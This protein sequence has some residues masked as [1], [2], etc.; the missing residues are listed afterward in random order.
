MA[1]FH[2]KLN[3]LPKAYFDGDCHSVPSRLTAE[4]IDR[5]EDPNTGWWSS[6]QPTPEA[7]G[8]LRQLC[9]TD[10]SW[11]DTEEYVTSEWGS[12]L[13]IW[14]EDGRVFSVTFRFAPRADNRSLLDQF[15]AIAREGHYLLWDSD[16]KAVFEP[17][18]AVVIEHLR[19]SRAVLFLKDP[20]RAI[21]EA[22]K[23]SSKQ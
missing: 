4:D 15:L 2:F 17:D 10:N 16:T 1:A 23:Q 14:W 22:A 6:H 19:V 5:G 11:G 3:L 7:L 13:R 12:D 20:A 9:L 8:R 18:D 21:L